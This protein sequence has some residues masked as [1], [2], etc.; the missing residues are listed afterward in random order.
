MRY[1][2]NRIRAT[3][4]A[5]ETAPDLGPPG[6]E[7]LLNQP[8]HFRSGFRCRRLIFADQAAEGGGKPVAIDYFG[9]FQG[10]GYGTSSGF[11]TF[12]TAAPGGF[13]I[14]L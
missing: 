13:I 8:Q 11:G 1:G 9:Q 2:A 6:F 7:R 3:D 10:G 4:A 12:D 14:A 5:I